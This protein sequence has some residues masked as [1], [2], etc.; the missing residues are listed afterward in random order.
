MENVQVDF[1][2]AFLDGMVYALT[3]LALLKWP[4]KGTNRMYGYRTPRAMKTQESWDYSQPYASRK[5]ILWGLI[6]LGLAFLTYILAPKNVRGQ[7]FIWV[8]IILAHVMPIIQ[9][10]LQLKRLFG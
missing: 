1:L 10:E 6:L 5:I 7:A 2:V 8:A 9:T 4:P 3:G